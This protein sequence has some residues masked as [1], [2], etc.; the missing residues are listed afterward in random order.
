[1]YSSNIVWIIKLGRM[2]WVGHVAYVGKKKD[3]SSS[4]RQN[5]KLEF[6]VL[7]SLNKMNS[8]SRN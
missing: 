5:I 4:P 6:T 7:L 8:V 3:A 2:K 1:M